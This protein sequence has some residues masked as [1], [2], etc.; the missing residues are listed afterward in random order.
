MSV[1]TR[2]I[3]PGHYETPDGQYRV[4]LVDPGQWQAQ[5]RIGAYWSWVS[6][7][8][9]KRDALAAIQLDRGGAA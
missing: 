8:P 1:K 7:V 9:T 4:V 3:E 6:T 2:R 5:R